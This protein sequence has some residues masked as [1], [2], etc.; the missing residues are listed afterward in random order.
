MQIGVGAATIVITPTVTIADIPAGATFVIVKAMFKYR[1]LENTYAGVNKLDGATIA[2]TSQ[3]WQ[4]K[5]TTAG[6]YVDAI[7]HVDDYNTLADTAREAGDV[8]P[9]GINIVAEVN[10]NG[11]YTFRWLLSK[12]DQDFIKYN[13]IQVGLVVAYSV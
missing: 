10:A 5:E 13:D 12:A 7:N 6:A 9:G 11:N 3:V 2:G 1:M 8:L 4:V